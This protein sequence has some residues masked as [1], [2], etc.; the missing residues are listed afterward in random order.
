MS[1]TT[2]NFTSEVK[3]ELIDALASDMDVARAAWVS[4]FGDN[5]RTR[6]SEDISKLINFLYNNKHMS[7]FEHGIFKFYIDCP[8]FVARE[9]MRHRTFSFNEVSGRY[10][11][12]DGKFYVPDASRPLV[13]KGRV[14]AYTFEPGTDEMYI[15]K[16]MSDMRAFEG[17]WK[18]Y[19]YQLQIGIAKETAR[20][21]LPVG[22]YTSFYASVDPRNLMQFLTLRND[23]HALY[24]IRQIAIQMEDAF[25]EKMP[26][27]YSAY[28]TAREKERYPLIDTTQIKDPLKWEP[29]KAPLDIIDTENNFLGGGWTCDGRGEIVLHNRG[30]YVPKHRKAT[31][32]VNVKADANYKE[33]ADK[34]ADLVKRTDEF[35]RRRQSERQD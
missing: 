33:T 5:S 4:N 26:L 35:G 21:V 23:K 24:E 34:I 29:A 13:Q 3:A 27:T 11:E 17:A 7:P 25:A 2:L 6:E 28:A 8:I 20:N 10:R 22:I 30:G 12:L 9:F 18:E 16:R 19:Q 14:G 15:L 32:S 1:K 31:Y